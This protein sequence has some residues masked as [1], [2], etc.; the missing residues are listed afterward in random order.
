MSELE[1]MM[2]AVGGQLNDPALL[3]QVQ[4]L[5]AGAQGLPTDALR[6]AAAGGDANAVKQAVGQFMNT[7]EGKQLAAK[8]MQAFGK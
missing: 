1:R 5:L 4:A 7:P 6:Q 2:Q 3:A 8:L